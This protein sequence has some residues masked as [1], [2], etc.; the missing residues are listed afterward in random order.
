M[1]LYMYIV[2]VINLMLLE[3]V[4]CTNCEIFVKKCIDHKQVFGYKVNK[5]IH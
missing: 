1:Y 4:L 2:G 3:S 5:N